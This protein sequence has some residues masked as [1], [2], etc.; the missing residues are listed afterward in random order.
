M[1]CLPRE[2]SVAIISLGRR[3][4]HWAEHLPPCDFHPAT[5]KK[6]SDSD[7]RQRNQLLSP[8]LISGV[9]AFMPV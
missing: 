3:L 1:K 8:G 5:G 9:P 2:I 4:F 7:R 6:A